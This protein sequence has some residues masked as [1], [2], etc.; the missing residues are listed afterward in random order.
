MRV[1]R[2]TRGGAQ[3]PIALT[4]GNFDGVHLGHQAMLQRLCD[5]A[6][7]S[8][9][10]A[11][12]LTFEPHPREF[13]SAAD[14]PAR[15]TSLREKL[16][17]FQTLDIDQVYVAHFD[18]PYA[19]MQ[20]LQ[21][22]EELL[23]KN[24][25]VRWLLVGDDFRFGAQRG[26]D[27]ALLKK[28]SASFDFVLESMGSIEVAGERVSSTGVREALAAADFA[29]AKRLLGRPYCISGRVAHGKKLGRELGF[30]TANIVL[31]RKRVPLN[32]IYAVKLHGIEPKPLPAVA[33]L[34]VRPTVM[35]GA[36]PLLE[37]HIL[38]FDR[39]IYGRR[40]SVEF[41][42][43]LRDEEK[44]PDLESL[45]RQIAIDVDNARIYLNSNL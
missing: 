12:V 43:K 29:R 37:I 25:N 1:F 33:S 31:K 21:F 5:A 41:L 11:S 34:G 18:R 17:L 7:S 38:D 10:P 45:R 6:R 2:G 40:V 24:L 4:I 15:L 28:A 23:V 13:F 30:P 26:G 44:Y 9:L 27:F 22:I 14:A 42:H 36:A 20:P 32:G 8:R 19:S 39:N 35:D 3:A 16:E